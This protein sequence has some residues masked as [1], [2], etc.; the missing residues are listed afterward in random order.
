MPVHVREQPV[1]AEELLDAVLTE[2]PAPAASAMRISS[3]PTVLVTTTI[4]TSS[5]TL[6]RRLRHRR[7]G[8]GRLRT[9]T[10]WA[11]SATP[12]RRRSQHHRETTPA[13]RDQ[14]RDTLADIN[15]VVGDPLERAARPPG[16]IS[17]K[18]T[19]YR[20][21]RAAGPARGRTVVEVIDRLVELRQLPSELEVAVV[22]R[23]ARR[24]QIR[25]RPGRPV[26]G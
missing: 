6:R 10:R 8:A 20:P 17:T 23:L 22:Q 4:V 18:P 13:L 7:P 21:R 12:R 9:A 11:S 1:L 19:R 26:P 25:G 14:V 2:F 15:R 5:G 16:P 3:I 24:V